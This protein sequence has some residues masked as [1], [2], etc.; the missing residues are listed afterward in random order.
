MKKKVKFFY[1][2]L[3]ILFLL[4]FSIR[5]EDTLAEHNKS[6]V[7]DA[8]SE[9]KFVVPE[10]SPITKEK[11]AISN[12]YGHF[13]Q[14]EYDMVT[15]SLQ[16]L[17]VS[18]NSTALADSF[19]PNS[20]YDKATGRIITGINH[21][22]YT[23]RSHRTINGKEVPENTYSYIQM[24]DTNGNDLGSVQASDKE[25]STVA[26][27]DSRTGANAWYSYASGIYDTGNSDYSMLWQSSVGPYLSTIQSNNNI[28][29][30][31]VE[32][33]YPADS[34]HVYNRSSLGIDNVVWA[35]PYFDKN[36]KLTDQYRM[37]AIN[38]ATGLST[39]SYD[40]QTLYDKQGFELVDKWYEGIVNQSFTSGSLSRKV[41]IVEIW[42]RNKTGETQQYINVWSGNPSST[43]KVNDILYTYK[44]E[45]GN[46]LSYL[47]EIST[48]SE[49]YF[50]EKTSKKTYLKRLNVTDLTEPEIVKTYPKGTN[51]LIKRSD[52]GEVSFVGST[53]SFEDDFS[54]LGFEASGNTTMVGLMDDDFNITTMSVVPNSK[55]GKNAMKFT[56]LIKLENDDYFFTGTILGEG[57]ATDNPNWVQ[58]EDYKTYEGTAIKNPPDLTYYT[59]A[60]YGILRNTADYP[61]L[62]YSPETARIKINMDDEAIKNADL[63]DNNSEKYKILSNWLITGSKDG[64]FSDNKA[65]QV[66][67]TSDLGNS[68]ASY[69]LEWL[70]ERINLNPNN[71]GGAIDW[72]SLGYDAKQIGPQ[73]VT[74]F[75]TDSMKQASSL[76]RWISNVDDQTVYDK[77]ENL[78][79]RAD[80][81]SI[82]LNDVH[83]LTE[84]MVKK[85]SKSL[86]WLA[87]P[88][89][90]EAVFTEKAEDNKLSNLV[91]VNKEQLAAIQEVSDTSDVKPYPLDLTYTDKVDGKEK[92]VTKRIWVF[93]TVDTTTIDNGVALYVNDFTIKLEEAQSATVTSVLKKDNYKQTQ[94]NAVVYDYLSQPQ[95]SNQLTPLTKGEVDG[96][97]KGLSIENSSMLRLKG[98]K[99]QEVIT[100]FVITYNIKTVAKVRVTIDDEFQLSYN[101]VRNKETITMD[102]IYLD[103]SVDNSFRSIEIKVPYNL[104]LNATT[105]PNGWVQLDSTTLGTSKVYRFNMKSKNDHSTIMSFLNELSYT[106]VKDFDEPGTIKISLREDELINDTPVLARK[107]VTPYEVVAKG[108]FELY[109]ESGWNQGGFISLEWE[110][111]SNASQTVTYDVY[112]NDVLYQENVSATE[113]KVSN[114]SDTYA[115]NG[116]DIIVT[117]LKDNSLLVNATDIGTPYTFEIRAKQK[118]TVKKSNKIKVE[119]MSDIQGYY[120]VMDEQPLSTPKTSGPL[121]IELS[122]PGVENE[123]KLTGVKENDK[124][125]HIC[126]VDRAGNISSTKHVEILNI[127]F[128]ETLGY[129]DYE[130]NFPQKIYVKGKLYNETLSYSEL[131]GGNKVIETNLKIGETQSLVPAQVVSGYGFLQ[132]MDT[133]FNP[134]GSSTVTVTSASQTYYGVYEKYVEMS[135][136]QIYAE[137]KNHGIYANLKTEQMVDNSANKYSLKPGLSLSKIIEDILS[138]ENDSFKLNYDGYDNVEASEY[139]VIVDGV[140]IETN[141]VPTKDF[142]LR[143]EYTGQIKIDVD[144]L[145]YGSIKITKE[146]EEIYDNPNKDQHLT[147]TNTTLNPNWRLNIS[148]PNGIQNVNTKEAYLGG[149]LIK[150]ATDKLYVNESGV[151]FSSQTN[152]NNQLVTNLLMDIKLYQ[153]LGNSK[154]NYAGEVLWSLSDGP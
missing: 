141:Q 74:Y 114:V 145:N 83:S 57:F 142:E 106:I 96:E 129:T 85:E 136:K 90:S 154:G 71:I 11:I 151:E 105:V 54:G 100:D 78:Y 12:G 117:K 80:N 31:E 62:I 41:G 70:Q 20:Y 122:N 33:K 130:A 101:L 110:N 68:I 59:N 133:A 6:I 15:R 49:Y 30:V 150:K 2:I 32:V 108:N 4:S 125:L 73:K 84:N 127:P 91:K 63:T 138:D 47:R 113:I 23:Y 52:S 76:S 13:K 43:G 10:D 88:T 18:T 92:T 75:V 95:K 99:N 36:T 131:A 48:D 134:L 112:Q 24:F 79:L 1:L 111:L 115:P 94:P 93:V 27:A 60:L 126:A 35:M 143:F 64:S 144:S 121:D 8:T 46:T 25:I 123:V 120:Y 38:P 69:D 89:N 103:N 124:Y 51:I 132:F 72:K 152:D 40:L 37:F 39:I 109:G 45:Q 29:R 128:A 21:S 149:L 16:K 116:E 19:L 53:N 97:A 118:D 98:A 135:I 77:T 140:E 66:T 61:P 28:N 44:A 137:D 81:F 7:I 104:V 67:D 102:D 17:N 107:W 146:K 5:G 58:K 139:H 55:D 153:N 56:D 22:N 86:S 87:E 42:N 14:N 82:S 3:P 34:T 65:I 119:M 50:I 9:D 148:L 26:G 147:I